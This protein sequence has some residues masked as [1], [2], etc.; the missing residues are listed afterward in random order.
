MKDRYLAGSKI[1]AVGSL[2]AA[3]IFL[4]SKTDCLYLGKLAVDPA[5]RGLGQARQRVDLAA[6]RARGL[7]LSALE[8]QRKV[9]LVENHRR[10]DRLGCIKTAEG[11][12]PGCSRVTGITMRVT[13]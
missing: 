2:P 3:C 9:E 12:Y 8:L 1:R 4:I 6:E 7:G 10:F 13:L 11:A 5:R